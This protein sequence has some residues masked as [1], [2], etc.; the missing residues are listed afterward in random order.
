MMSKAKRPSSPIRRA[1]WV[2]AAGVGFYVALPALVKVVGASP[3]LFSLEPWWLLVALATEFG[4]F[5]CAMALL[6]LSVRS[7]DWYAVVTAG[8]AGNAVTNVLPSGGAAGAGVQYRMLV[9][10][11]MTTGQAAG[12]LA[13]TG[14]L[15]LAGLLILPVFALP[16]LLG[17]TTVSS[18]LL[19]AGELGIVGFVFIASFGVLILTTDQVLEWVGR[20]VQWLLNRTWR[21]HRRT[22]N[23]PGRL[24]EQRN[25]VRA[26]LGRNWRR[27][28]VLVAGRIGLDYF[29]LLAALRATGAKPNPSLV[30][31]AYAATA[32]IT[33]V[34]LTPGGLGI[35]EASLTG[36]LV[37]AG[38]PSSSAVVA[39]LAFRIG[40]YWLPTIGGGIA[41]VLARRRYG[42]MGER[43]PVQ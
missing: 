20:A 37:L 12:G 25:L 29:S 34:P 36:L 30:L 14:V 15:N 9:A 18:G 42:S 28:V 22:T 35:V 11:G 16:V 6:R 1:I 38:I 43:V 39:T 32:V 7:K 27:A 24:I 3:R 40:S 8:L 5:L 10:A 23:L 41:Y 13:T 31:L 19:H 26:G 33:L 4:S 2:L 21:R 17:G